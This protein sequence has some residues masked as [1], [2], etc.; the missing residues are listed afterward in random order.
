M[1]FFGETYTTTGR[2]TRPRQ[3][4][5]N[6][7]NEAAR[8][9]RRNSSHSLASAIYLTKFTPELASLSEPLRFLTRKNAIFEWTQQHT[10]AFE[11]IKQTLM[12]EQEL[13]HFDPEKETVIQTDASIKGLRCMPTTRR[14]TSILHIQIHWRSREKLRCHR[15]RVP[16]SCSGH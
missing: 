8:K 6:Q 2:K 16:S 5:S 15:A 13:A 7:N 10:K 14:Q 9:T 11:R 12:K 3:G 1:S 4:R